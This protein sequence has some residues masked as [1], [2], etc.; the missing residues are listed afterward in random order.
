MEK[1]LLNFEIGYYSNHRA[2]IDQKVIPAINEFIAELLRLNLTPSAELI[3]DCFQNR[4]E[5]AGK[6]LIEDA[7]KEINRL[8]LKNI[9][10]TTAMIE[11]AKGQAADLRKQCDKYDSDVINNLQYITFINGQAVCTPEDDIRLKERHSLFVYSEPGLAA[12]E[13]AVEVVAKLNELKA[14]FKKP[15]INDFKGL[16]KIITC[17]ET[18]GYKVAPADFDYLTADQ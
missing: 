6:R 18:A 9:V 2:I 14:M 12:Y 7:Q 5:L 4:C 3:T 11:G 1:I 17:D 10:L 15:F 13:L 16:R 8:K